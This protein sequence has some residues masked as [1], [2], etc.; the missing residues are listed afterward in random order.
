MYTYYFE[1]LTV[2]QDSKELVVLIYKFTRGFPES[3]K[4]GV[5]NQ[6]QR[7]AVSVTANISEGSSRAT[8]KDQASYTTRAYSS[9]MEVLNLLIISFELD[10]ISE[11]DYLEARTLINKISNK[12]NALKKSQLI[13]N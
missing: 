5:V 8:G 11:E 1:K 2:W 4:Y 12:I 3:E 7:A 10:C 6:L 9:L 13:N